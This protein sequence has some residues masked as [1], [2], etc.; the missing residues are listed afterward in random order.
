MKAGVILL[1]LL[2]A[3][4]TWWW[5]TRTP[6]ETRRK[7]ALRFHGFVKGLAIGIGVYV[8]LTLSALVYLALASR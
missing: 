4:A 5:I 8:V 3:A 6:N 1:S 2:A 7:S